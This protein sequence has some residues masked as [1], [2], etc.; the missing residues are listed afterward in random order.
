MT[1][2]FEN[3]L[4]KENGMEGQEKAQACFIS[5]WA[6]LFCT[7]VCLTLNPTDCSPL[8]TPQAP[9]SMGFTRQEK[10]SALPFPTLASLPDPVIKPASL[11]F[12]AWQMDS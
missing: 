3:H 5:V 8:P 1:G 6:L 2:A 10:W 7:Q 11:E 9:L 4:S 12:P